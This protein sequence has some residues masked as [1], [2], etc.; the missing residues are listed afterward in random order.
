MCGRPPAHL[1]E[2][3]PGPLPTLAAEV[4]QVGGGEQVDRLLHVVPGG[5]LEP[6]L[7]AG[8]SLPDA[9]LEGVPVDGDPGA[10]PPGMVRGVEAEEGHQS[11]LESAGQAPVVPADD[12]D[13]AEEA[14]RAGG[15][16]VEIG[17]RETGHPVPWRRRVALTTVDARSSGAASQRASRTSAVAASAT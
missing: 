17:V 11:V 4:L 12:Q 5:G 15:D 1:V 7:H 16:P 13:P 10:V 14:V 3:V 8:E 6:R 2:A 9:G